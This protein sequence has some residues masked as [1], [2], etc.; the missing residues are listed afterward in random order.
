MNERKKHKH[1]QK[2]IVKVTIERSY[3]L[4]FPEKH[5]PPML[6]RLVLGT[7]DQGIMELPEH[8]YSCINHN[9][10]KQVG[11]TPPLLSAIPY[12]RY[13]YDNGVQQI[14]ENAVFEVPQ[15]QTIQKKTNQLAT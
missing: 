2:L 7:R 5:P 6:H 9:V 8:Y 4:F 12:S 10:G 1:V 11:K 15:L 14:H 13:S 3:L